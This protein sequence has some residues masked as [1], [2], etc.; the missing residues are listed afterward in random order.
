MKVVLTHQNVVLP[1]CAVG[2]LAGNTHVNAV[3]SMAFYTLLAAYY[4]TFVSFP[5]PFSKK[6]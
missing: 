6:K 3:R 2:A 5:F 1:A 4:A